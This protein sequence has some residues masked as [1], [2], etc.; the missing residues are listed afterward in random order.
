MEKVADL[1][2]RVAGAVSAAEGTGTG[3]PAR[4]DKVAEMERDAARLRGELAEAKGEL[5]RRHEESTVAEQVWRQKIAALEENVAALEGEADGLRSRLA[6]REREYAARL[7]AA[8]NETA[9]KL[10]ELEKIFQDFKKASHDR[11]TAMRAAGEKEKKALEERIA[12][13]NAEVQQLSELYGSFGPARSIGR[14]VERLAGD[15]ILLISGGVQ[16]RVRPGMKFDVHRPIGAHNRRVGS[17]KV[18]RVMD[19][20]SMAVPTYADAEILVCPETGRAVLEPGARFSPFAV[21]K[22]GKPLALRKAGETALPL[23]APAIGDF[24]DNPFY[25]PMRPMTFVLSPALSGNACAVKIIETLGGVVRGAGESADFL[26]VADETERPAV[27][28]GIRP[29]TIE[30]LAGYL[31]PKPLV[32][33]AAQRACAAPGQ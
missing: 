7:E 9:A 3:D 28:K 31:D 30:H 24:I 15:Q 14:I 26:V 22:D 12:G 20:Y 10:G 29:V 27:A 33:S 4:Q 18:I 19:G 13:L 23:D 8:R 1:E 32:G 25:D 11:E 6:E 5:T 21:G 16:E 17:V 2:K